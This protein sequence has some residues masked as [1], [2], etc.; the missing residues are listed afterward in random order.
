MNTIDAIMARRSV[1]AYNDKPVSD[2]D[3]KFIM[4]A[5]VQAPSGMNTQPWYFVVLKSDDAKQKLLNVMDEVSEK[6][7]PELEERFAKFPEVI[8]ETKSFVKTLGGANV[9]VLAFSQ[10]KETD[11]Q[12]SIDI[13]ESV[14]AATENLMLAAADKGIGSCWLTAPLKAQKSEELRK[15][16][17]A[18]KGD[19]MALI[20]LGYAAKPAVAP[21]RKDGR[22]VII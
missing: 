19:L 17:A 4:E 3:L 7:T 20:T 13:M 8:K 5:A 21:K 12:K 18:D 1:R 10:K 15:I 22:Y 9:Y 6:M 16:F 14:S 2:E 11:V